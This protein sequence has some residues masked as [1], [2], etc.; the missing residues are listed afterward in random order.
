[1]SALR[2]VANGVEAKER[3]LECQIDQSSTDGDETELRY[4]GSCLVG[5]AK[6]RQQKARIVSEDGIDEENVLAEGLVR[7]KVYHIV[8]VVGMRRSPQGIHGC[9]RSGPHVRGCSCALGASVFLLR[10]TARSLGKQVAAL[11]ID[12]LTTTPPTTDTTP[13]R[14]LPFNC[15][16]ND[17]PILDPRRL[18]HTPSAPS[19]ARRS[20]AQHGGNPSQACHRR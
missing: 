4:P 3:S 15:T 7:A 2:N 16:P 6:T 10:S 8:N 5:V 18:Q 1:M 14:Q 19:R 12:Y 17:R 20:V 13:S 9:W 11:V